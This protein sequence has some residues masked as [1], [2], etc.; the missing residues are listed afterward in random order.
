MGG[1]R[2]RPDWFFS[3]RIARWARPGACDTFIVEVMGSVEDSGK[4]CHTA[5]RIDSAI[6]TDSRTYYSYNANNRPIRIVSVDA[7][8]SDT[9]F[10]TYDSF[11][12]GS[13]RLGS[14]A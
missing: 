11:R 7:S 13:L 9:T 3:F 6:F 1:Q 8:D 14:L 12:V 5:G 2:R 10:Y 4:F